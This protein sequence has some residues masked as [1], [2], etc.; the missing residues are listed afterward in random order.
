MPT[1]VFVSDG[2]G[3]IVVSLDQFSSSPSLWGE[4]D[5]RNKELADSRPLVW[6]G[7]AELP[8]RE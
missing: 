7:V 2:P 5:K 8:A 4:R 3:T 6:T 1:S